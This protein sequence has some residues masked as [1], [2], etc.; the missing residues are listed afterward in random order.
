MSPFSSTHP[1]LG[2]ETRHKLENKTSFHREDVLSNKIAT[3]SSQGDYLHEIF[4]INYFISIQQ[5]LMGHDIVA[6]LVK[7][8][9]VD[10]EVHTST[11]ADR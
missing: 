7:G 9:S 11:H 3:P 4:L 10:I 6:M 8:V 1:L 5:P 2:I